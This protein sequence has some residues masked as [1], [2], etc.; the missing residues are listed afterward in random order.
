M[1]DREPE[2]WRASL[3]NAVPLAPSASDTAAR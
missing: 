2:S 1:A 3:M